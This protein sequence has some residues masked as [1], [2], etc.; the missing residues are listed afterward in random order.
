MEKLTT[1]I[2]PYIPS[3]LFSSVSSHRLEISGD[4][5]SLQEFNVEYINSI[6]FQAKEN[7]VTNIDKRLDL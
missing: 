2:S 1:V 3:S 7:V 4:F 5:Q 6:S